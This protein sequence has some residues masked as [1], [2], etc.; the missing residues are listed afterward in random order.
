[1]AEER[2]NGSA[3]FPLSV[4][5]AFALV[6][7]LAYVVAVRVTPLL[8]GR[9]GTDQRREGAAEEGAPEGARASPLV[10]TV[11]ERE[12]GGVAD[13]KGPRDGGESR[14]NEGAS[15]AGHGKERVVETFGAYVDGLGKAPG[16]EELADGAAVA[17]EAVVSDQAPLTPTRKV[18]VKE[19]Y[20]LKSS[21][22][23]V[24]NRLNN[25][26]G[27]CGK[28]RRPIPLSRFDTPEQRG[29]KEAENQRRTARNKANEAKQR[30]LRRSCQ[31]VKGTLLE[32]PKR[33]EIRYLTE[34]EI[35]S[36]IGRLTV[37]DEY[38]KYAVPAHERKWHE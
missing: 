9:W 30:E 22:R 4:V 14:P 12:R 23:L 27:K 10:G 8:D 33:S 34:D 25:E 18:L 29:R 24:Y 3:Y 1:M 37:P 15:S 21:W 20:S 5:L 16:E 36:Y 2:D 19:L 13:Q 6:V 26:L 38:L 35:R 11:D 7:V 17:R 28:R 31:V 32:I